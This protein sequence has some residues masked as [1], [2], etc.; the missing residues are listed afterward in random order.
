MQKKGRQVALRR[1]LEI[2]SVDVNQIFSAAG[3][4]TGEAEKALGIFLGKSVQTGKELQLPEDLVKI[5]RMIRQKRQ[6]RIRK[7]VSVV[8]FLKIREIK[9]GS[10]IMDQ[11]SGMFVQVIGKC[12]QKLRFL[13]RPVQEPLTEFRFAPGYR[14]IIIQDADQIEMRKAGG[15]TGRFDIDKDCGIYVCFG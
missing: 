13:I 4:L 7:P 9:S 10:V 3:I 8:F 5:C 11:C 6:E 14:R 15:K 12:M 2:P 1:A